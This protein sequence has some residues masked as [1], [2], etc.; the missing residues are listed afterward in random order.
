MM[1]N[2]FGMLPYWWVVIPG[3]LLGLY[4]QIR[5][6]AVYGRYLD[7]PIENGITGAEA[8]REILNHA[9]LTNIPVEEIP[10]QLSDHYDPVKKVLCLSTDNF[11]GRSISAVGVA[12]HESGHALQQQ[13]A[14][15]LFNLRM[16]VVP[17]T[18]FASFAYSAIFFMG[19]FLGLHVFYK[20]IGI[21]I[22]IFLVLTFFQLITLPVEY[23]A[24][25]RAKQQL[26][27]L[28]LVQADESA[29]VARVLNAAALTYVA[30]LVTTLLTLLKFIMIARSNERD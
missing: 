15:G 1:W 3:F 28:G 29:A 22:G 25:R 26:I 17:A 8:A 13:A 4:A 6:S 11:H 18:Q 30:A 19:L 12:A 2:W 20:F 27:K 7:V 10:G 9:G 14:Y 23:D 16:M 21:I 5:L 24:S